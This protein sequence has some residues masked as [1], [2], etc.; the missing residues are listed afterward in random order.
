MDAAELE[1]AI[2]QA[3]KGK[4]PAT[5]D[6]IMDNL[7]KKEPLPSYEDIVADDRKWELGSKL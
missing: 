4:A 1:Q 7:M 5:R 6:L 2:K 3:E